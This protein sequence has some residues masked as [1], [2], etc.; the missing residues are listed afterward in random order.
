VTRQTIDFGIDLGTTNSA[1]AVL[2]GTDAQI[3]KSTSDVLQMEYTP[4]AVWIDQKG[5][6]KV[7]RMAKERETAAIG[8]VSVEFKLKMGKT[9]EVPFPCGVKMSPEALSAEV[10]KALKKDVRVSMSEEMEAAVITV[11]AAFELPQC[12]ATT[13][14]AKLAGLHTAPLLQEPSAAALA[15]GL[16]AEEDNR[17]WLVYD[18]GGG[19]FDAALVKL[20]DGEISPVNHAGDNHLGG[21]F[22][23][24]EIVERLLIPAVV[25][26]HNV[27]YFERGNV[28]WQTAIA[29]LKYH[30]EIAKIRLSGS[31]EQEIEIEGLHNR[32]NSQVF[33]FNFTLHKADLERLFDPIIDRT[34]RL[35][36]KV[37]EEK[38]IRRDQVAKLILVG[39]PTLT[40]YLRE[41]L[42]D[43]NSGLGIPLDFHI[44]PLTAVARGAAMFAGTQRLVTDGVRAPVAPGTLAIEFPKDCKTMGSDAEPEVFGRVVMP[45]GQSASG[46]T[47]E[48]VNREAQPAWRSGK[49]GLSA[50]G[51]FD[52][53][54][55]AE[56]GRANVFFIEVCDATGRPCP[57]EPPQHTYVF[58]T[59][60]VSDRPPLINTLAVAL[61]NNKVQPFLK[62]GTALSAKSRSD[63]HSTVEV[64]PGEAKDALCIP[65]IEGEKSRADR[66]V[67]IGK[68]IVRGTEV[69]RAVPA[70]STIEVTV[71]CD[72]SRNIV[73]RAYVPILD[74]GPEARAE[75][76]ARFDFDDYGAEARNPEKLAREVDEEKRRFEELR[77]RAREHGVPEA[78]ELARRIE[79]DRVLSDAQEAAAKAKHGDDEAE[80]CHK[81]LLELRAEIDKVEDALALPQLVAD[82]EKTLADAKK[83]TTDPHFNA[84]ADEKRQVGEQEKALR[85]AIDAKDSD[86]VRHSQNELEG[87]IYGIL[88]RKDDFH[89][90]RFD[91]LSKM[92]D[93]TRD[94]EQARR[95]VEQGRRA[96]ERGDMVA[97]RAANRQ[98][99]SL[100]PNDE[101][102]LTGWDSTVF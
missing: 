66:N 22:L 94:P 44:D 52:T 69:A 23:D 19:T 83:I 59:F 101:P 51:R 72:T 42:K 90:V 64:R 12:A 17:L 5:R 27:S 6:I 41:R 57:T 24:W 70:G 78:Q 81:R 25:K 71:E 2:R 34:I 38:E 97:L 10:L 58:T 86:G 84:S 37:L 15:Y 7:G 93:R 89:V 96:I 53:Q 102:G 47:I 49:V 1:V 92:V 46:Y 91:R 48:F 61:A 63:L 28:E 39:G 67:L 85:R 40:P 60:Q 16:R 82:A 8:D 30:A 26:Q 55:W 56:K 68:L 88:F 65:V 99:V 4:S 76:E 77:Q 14:A 31:N 54:L 80:R 9:D 45:E 20:R 87:I 50:E 29:M 98:I 36:R 74:A 32:D 95:F 73:A 13:R 3:V 21:K 75:F 79:A 18:L 33:D 43:S 11:P 62:K 35:C 100:L